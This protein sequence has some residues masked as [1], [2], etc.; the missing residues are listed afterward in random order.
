MFCNLFPPL[1]L[2]KLSRGQGD[3]AFNLFVTMGETP[4]S[5]WLSL[6]NISS[7]VLQLLDKSFEMYLRKVTEAY[8]ESELF[9]FWPIS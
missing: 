9:T 3:F 6:D 5:Q 8:L 7:T 2:P 1:L 4:L